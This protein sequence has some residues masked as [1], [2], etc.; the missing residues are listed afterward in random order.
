M[1]AILSNH[2][3]NLS[4]DACFVVQSEFAKIEKRLRM[5]VNT[6]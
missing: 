3:K 5:T 4:R 2:G 1:I 6:E